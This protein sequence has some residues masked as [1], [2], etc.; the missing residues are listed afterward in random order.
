MKVASSQPSESYM[1]SASVNSGQFKRCQP[2]RYRYSVVCGD[3]KVSNNSFIDKLLGVRPKWSMANH[4]TLLRVHEKDGYSIIVKSG[5]AWS[6]TK[7][8]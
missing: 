4:S 8:N 5:R 1:L 7:I 3:E 2:G 6:M